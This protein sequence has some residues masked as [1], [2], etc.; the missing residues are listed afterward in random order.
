MTHGIGDLD[1]KQL[2][3]A[4]IVA[5]QALPAIFPNQ[6]RNMGGLELGAWTTAKILAERQLGSQIVVRAPNSGHSAHR[7][8]VDVIALSDPREYIRRNVS[9]CVE[10][11]DGVRLKRFSI[12]LLWQIPYLAITW[13]WR[14]RDPQPMQPD[15]RLESITTDAWITLG[16]SRESAGVIATAIEQ[17][18][19]SL[20]MLMSNADVDPAYKSDTQSR[21]AYGEIAE[22][23]LFAI[24]NATTIV[25]QTNYQQRMLQQHFQRDGV[26]IPTSIDPLPWQSATVNTGD[27]VLWVGRYDTF[28][29]R[30]RL[31]IEIARRLPEIPFVM[32]VNLSD[33]AV[34]DEIVA[35]L[36][37]NVELVDYVAA[38]EMPSMF[39]RSRLFLS[40][41]S[42]DY[43]GFPR[44]LLQATAAGKPI[45]SLDD[46]DGFIRASRAG[47]VTGCDVEEA[48]REITLYWNQSDR[49][50]QI[51]ATQFLLDHHTNDAI[52]KRLENAL[53]NALEQI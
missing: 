32:V 43:E 29:K 25:C 51:F 12:R 31:A 22:H 5:W 33:P 8:G 9:S 23:C 38:E 42:A 10:V 27:Y 46:F 16:T 36:P 41:G 44:V 7:E 2:K 49:C 47:T 4:T 48:A 40:T 45:V 17:N 1:P 13:P 21:N 19:P 14:V 30:P 26:V 11:N 37:D 34:H 15:P 18:K 52:G 24:K 20:L 39:G 53:I 3:N 6:G 28:H 50:D 35:T